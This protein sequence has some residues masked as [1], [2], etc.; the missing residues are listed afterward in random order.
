VIVEQFIASF[1]QPPGELILDFDATDDPVH[2]H[3]EWCFFH[4]YYDSY[5]FL[6]LYRILRRAVVVE[7]PAPIKGRCGQTC[8]GNSG[9]IGQALACGLAAGA[10]HHAS[11][12]G[13]CRHKMLSW[14]E[15]HGVY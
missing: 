5:C 15:R 13:F 9:A 1:A 8:V 11:D 14:C 12:W 3:Q 6:P 10:Y 4:G 7:L 2:G